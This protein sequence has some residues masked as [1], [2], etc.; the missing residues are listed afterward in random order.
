M[1]YLDLPNEVDM[2][3]LDV[4]DFFKDDGKIDN[5]IVNGNVHTNFFFPLYYRIRIRK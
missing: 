4:F 3:H 1:N 5:L 2:T